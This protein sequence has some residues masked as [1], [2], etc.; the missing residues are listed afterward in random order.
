MKKVYQKPQ[1]LVEDMLLD[2]A[3]ATATSCKINF[4]TDPDIPFL[5]ELG[6]FL[7]KSSCMYVV[8]PDGGFDLDNDGKVEEG[9]HDTVCYHS[10]IDQLFGS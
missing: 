9:F 6:C 8:A 5:K 4:N 1:I 7:D 3:I 10:N 2:N